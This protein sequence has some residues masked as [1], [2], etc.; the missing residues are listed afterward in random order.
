MKQVVLDLYWS[1]RTNL[2]SM[3][4]SK[5]KLSDRIKYEKAL[6]QMDSIQQII[7]KFNF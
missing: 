2:Q 4:V 7:D 3:E 6:V 5:M 1:A